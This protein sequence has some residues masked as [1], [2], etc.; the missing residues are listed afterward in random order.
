MS[1]PARSGKSTSNNSNSNTLSHLL[2]TV[3]IYNTYNTYNDNNDNNA[4]SMAAPNNVS[5]LP[6]TIP[7]SATT[8]QNHSQQQQQSSTANNS[9]S[10]GLPHT[11]AG[12][13]RGMHH[14]DLARALAFPL[15]GAPPAPVMNANDILRLAG[16]RGHGTATTTLELLQGLQQLAQLTQQQQAPPNIP[17]AQALAQLE[18]QTSSGSANRSNI[19]T[20]SSL[21]VSQVEPGNVTSGS[22]SGPTEST[23]E[24]STAEADSSGAST[25]NNVGTP[26]GTI[27]VPCRARGMPVVHNFR[28]SWFFGWMELFFCLLLLFL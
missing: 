27:I 23:N 18:T 13:G 7:S 3:G 9:F 10:A 17:N 1:P 16:L 24:S 20:H 4:T 26:P 5:S 6:D 8:A 12:L 21:A 2:S 19:S 11:M 22:G 28:V 25:T 15:V 14:Q